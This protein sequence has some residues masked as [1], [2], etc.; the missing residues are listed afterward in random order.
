MP[1]GFALIVALVIVGGLA[2]LVPTETLVAAN[3][4]TPAG[5]ALMRRFISRSRRFRL[6]GGLVGIAISMVITAT[7]TDASGSVTIGLLPALA[8]AV[9]GS[10]LAEAFRIRAARGP[11]TASLGIRHD[12]DY[13]DPTADLRERIIAATTAAVTVAA[14]AQENWG[15]VGLFGAI[16]AAGLLRRWAQHRVAMRG[17]PALEPD[18]AEADDQVRRMAVRHGLARPMVTLMTLLASTQAAMLGSGYEEASLPGQVAGLLSLALAVAGVVWWWT[19]RNFGSPSANRDRLRS[20]A[21]LGLVFL[22]IV[23]VTLLARATL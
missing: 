18:L 1:V 11:R 23:A 8:G 19:N 15:A 9:A 20:V 17:R 16:I 5:R 22:G 3:A 4:T 13:S 2:L 14:V 21:V 6:I 12:I 7:R 10:I